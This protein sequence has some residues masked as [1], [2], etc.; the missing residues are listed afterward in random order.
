MINLQN[1]IVMTSGGW[2]E[3]MEKSIIIYKNKSLHFHIDKF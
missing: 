2:V 1:L 3:G